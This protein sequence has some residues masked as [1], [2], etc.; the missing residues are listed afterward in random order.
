MIDNG[1]F[2]VA[3]EK[4]SSSRGPPYFAHDKSH[5]AYCEDTTETNTQDTSK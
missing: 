2:Y 4:L 1:M 5:Q 3:M